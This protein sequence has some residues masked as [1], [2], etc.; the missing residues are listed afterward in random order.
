MKVRTSMKVDRISD[1]GVEDVGGWPQFTETVDT[2]SSII[3]QTTQLVGTTHEAVST[4][5]VSGTP[6]AVVRNEHASA[7][8]Q[9]GVEVAATFYPLI[10]IPP[11][12][13]AKIPRFSNLAN[14]YVESDT[15]STPVTIS[16]HQ[17]SA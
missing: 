15:A 12:E 2:T 3:H 10:D 7:I 9:L 11:G 6:L 13:T 14:L 17:I 1:A 8:V 4:G 5:D 16:L